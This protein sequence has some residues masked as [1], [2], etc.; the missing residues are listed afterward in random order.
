MGQAAYDQ[1]VVSVNEKLV[2]VLSSNLSPCLEVWELKR[3]LVSNSANTL[4]PLKPHLLRRIHTLRGE[5]ETNKITLSSS[6]G[7]AAL[8][9]L[10]F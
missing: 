9:C 3:I 7:K 5:K 10:L 8:F 4:H 6:S 1:A 2:C